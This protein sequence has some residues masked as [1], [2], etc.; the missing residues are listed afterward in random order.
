MLECGH[1]CFGLCGEPCLRVCPICD[2]INFDKALGEHFQG[3]RQYY[4][5]PCGHIFD[6]EYLDQHMERCFDTSPYP[7]G[8]L[9]CPVN[10]CITPISTSFRYSE[11][12]KLCME[13]VQQVRRKI[14]DCLYTLKDQ[15][16]IVYDSLQK[17]NSICRR[18]L[19]HLKNLYSE[20]LYLISL[21]SRTVATS[22]NL[23]DSTCCIGIDLNSRIQYLCS[24]FDYDKAGLS[25]TLVQDFERMYL[26]QCLV[27]QVH[28]AKKHSTGAPK[29]KSIRDANNFLQTLVSNRKC[30][31]MTKVKFYDYS[32]PLGIEFPATV[33]YDFKRFFVTINPNHPILQKGM[34]WLCPKDHYYCTPASMS[35]NISHHCPECKGELFLVLLHSVMFLNSCPASDIRTRRCV[36]VIVNCKYLYCSLVKLHLLVLIYI[37]FILC[38]VF[39]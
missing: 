5:L 27:S 12:A 17:N 2:R 19:P 14:K 15:A 32:K 26:Q 3:D 11:I 33:A 35:K 20:H 4:Q 34:W 22:D 8:R 37:I 10:S 29:A 25:F 39:F 30:Q 38:R 23:N 36:Y 9:C 18:E 31:K 28:L 21:L 16:S 24:L 13:R 1:F 7:I 6:V